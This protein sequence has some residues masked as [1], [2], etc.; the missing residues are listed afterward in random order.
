MGKEFSKKYSSALLELSD[1]KISNL[2]YV[3]FLNYIG[4]QTKPIQ[5]DGFFMGVAKLYPLWFVLFNLLLVFESDYLIGSY[6]LNSLL[7]PLLSSIICSFFFVIQRKLY[8]L[9]CWDEL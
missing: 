6:V 5:Y 1:H 7:F 2:P 3:R 9:Q 4:I 8:K